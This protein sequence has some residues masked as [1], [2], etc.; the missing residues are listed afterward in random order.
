M[1][2]IVS[3][4]YSL[5]DLLRLSESQLEELYLA[6]S[7]PKMEALR[8]RHH[9]RLLSVCNMPAMLA[10]P[11]CYFAGSVFF[12]WKGKIFFPTDEQRG[13]G[14]NLLVSHRHQHWKFTTHIGPSRAGEFDAMQ[15]GYDLDE[16]PSVVR[17]MRD[18]L[19]QLSPGLYLGQAYLPRPS[20][21]RL[22]LYFGLASWSANAEDS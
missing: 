14:R 12:P 13:I 7:T 18:E 15:L 1:S 2:S 8:G 10:G 20:G 21:D 22:L 16:N 9:G 6:A 5:D 17:L 19:R 11:L 4:E 3:T